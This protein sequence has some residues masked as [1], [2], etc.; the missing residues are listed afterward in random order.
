MTETDYPK[1]TL[2][3]HGKVTGKQVNK[4]REIRLTVHENVRK[5]LY[6]EKKTNETNKT[7]IRPIQKQRHLPPEH[8]EY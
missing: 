2:S 1:I 8:K 7:T 3:S 4:N 5:T 6:S